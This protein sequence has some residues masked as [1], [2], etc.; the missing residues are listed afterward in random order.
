[1]IDL[2]DPAARERTHFDRTT[3]LRGPS[4]ADD[5]P[6]FEI[7]LHES[8]ASLRGVHGGYMAS[9]AVRA[10]EIVTPDRTVRTVT[11]SFLRPGAVG[12]ARLDVDVLR[13]GRTFS[14]LEVG[15]YQQERLVCVS[16]VTAHV[17]G[18]GAEWSPPVTDR[19]A[20]LAN[21][22]SFTPPPMIRHFEHAELRLDPETIPDASADTA[23]V[24]GH[25]RPLESRLVDAAWLVMIGDWFPPSPFRRLAPPAG[26]VSIDY[27]VHIHRLPSGDDA[28]DGAWLEGV[29]NTADS[30]GAIALERG[31]LCAADG[32]AIAET[33][34]TRY[35]GG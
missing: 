16:R 15:L 13:N 22:I 30:T 9:L 18:Q 32:V 7:D 25:V 20:P 21:C 23:R 4:S 26:G 10:A 11:T 3:Q 14:T 34:H 2:D 28:G 5:R 8:W 24:A 27:T 35:T 29:F 33:F 31:V 19:P 17:P 6:S 12:P 1:M